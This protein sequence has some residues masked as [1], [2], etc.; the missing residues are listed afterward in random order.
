MVKK[1]MSVETKENITPFALSIVISFA[2]ICYSFNC[3]LS[4]SLF[5]VSFY[6]LFL[7]VS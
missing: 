3:L 4:L 6:Y 7:L 1:K 2:I 5:I